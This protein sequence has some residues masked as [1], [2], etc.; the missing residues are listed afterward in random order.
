MVK[1]SLEDNEDD[2]AR[3]EIYKWWIGTSFT[4]INDYGS[5]SEFKKG[6]N[7][8]DIEDGSYKSYR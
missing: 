4:K 7:Q 1:G 3:L 5:K 6:F 2:T 8:S